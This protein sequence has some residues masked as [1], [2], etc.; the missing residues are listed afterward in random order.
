MKVAL[1]AASAVSFF[2]TVSGGSA[3]AFDCNKASTKIERAICAD[4]ALK[5]AD[6]A[7]SAAYSGLKHSLQGNE[8][9]MLQ[10]AQKRWLSIR[11]DRCASETGQDL[12]TCLLDFTK[13][14]RL[15]LEGAPESGPGAGARI[16][17]IFIQQ[18]GGAKRYDVD[19]TLLRFA[20]ADTAGQ[21][22]FNRELD[23]IAKKAP[24]GQQNEDVM[25]GMQLS[26]IA[27][28]AL[29]YASPKVISSAITIWSFDGGAHGNGGLT[30]VNV[31]LI[32]GRN[33]TFDALF[34]PADKEPLV[35]SCRQQIKDQK[36][37]KMDGEEFKPADD[38]NYQDST[39]E[40]HVSDLSRWS[41]TSEDAVV[42]FDAYAI[43]SYAEGSY[44]C[45]YAM[46]LLRSL[47]RDP[48]LLP[49]E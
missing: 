24:L 31:D 19:Y 13:E 45:T 37:E 28:A 41:F 38:P 2:F 5:A 22:L 42:T 46:G 44:T 11:H 23:A 17:P 27:L 3:V 39:I 25:E 18:E 30:N 36:T 48:A 40:E 14:R 26:A 35:V 34:D 43:G 8:A 16:I 32:G 20:D 9:S 4:P 15:L 1:F 6:D 33:I 49:E 12:T 7:M 10:L 47:A 21:K 29:S